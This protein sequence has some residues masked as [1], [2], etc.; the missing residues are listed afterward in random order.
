MI[1]SQ[2]CHY[3]APGPE[4]LIVSHYPVTL[5]PA[6]LAMSG[7][8]GIPP[9]PALHTNMPVVFSARARLNWLSQGWAVRSESS[10]D[11]DGDKNWPGST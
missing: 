10:D 8:S 6:L 1:G 7:L 3:L 9:L 2:C 5:L 4:S 11:R